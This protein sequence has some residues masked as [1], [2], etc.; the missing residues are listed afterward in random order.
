MS[1][2][3]FPLSCGP[4][5][6]RRRPVDG[7][8]SE[9]D[10]A[11]DD[12]IAR[13]PAA[14]SDDRSLT[15]ARTVI[16]LKDLLWMV[17]DSLETGRKECSHSSQWLP[18]AQQACARATELVSQLQDPSRRTGSGRE[19]IDVSAVASETVAIIRATF[20][21]HVRLELELPEHPL[22]VHADQGELGRALMNLL[23]N[24]RDAVFQRLE[25]SAEGCGYE[26][27][28]DVVVGVY[29][30]RGCG[31][32]VDAAVGVSIS[33]RDNGG[34]MPPEV[35][36]RL[37]EPFFTTKAR[38]KGSGLGLVTARAIVADHG[39]TIGVSSKLGCGTNFVVRLPLADRASVVVDRAGRE[40]LSSD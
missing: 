8:F 27:R 9:S 17:G 37:F 11:V 2:D 29:D 34:G 28:V 30:G 21:R 15:L 12:P 4:E 25:A 1:L 19:F 6:R 3:P 35:C 33:V 14:G 23:V 18:R 20:G 5:L 22:R 36:E 13:P 10:P 24:A 40:A 26:P 31:C 7:Y 32:A 16:D 39:G 38:G